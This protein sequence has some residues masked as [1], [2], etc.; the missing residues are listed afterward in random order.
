MTSLYIHYFFLLLVSS[1]FLGCEPVVP[2][3]RYDLSECK[4]ELLEANHFQEEM[5]IDHI[6]VCKKERIMYLY[7]DKE[8]IQEIPISLG[9]NPLGHKI[10]QGDC[11]TPEGEY[12]IRK[13]ICSP[14]Y[15]RSLSISYPRPIDTQK[16]TQRGVKAGGH[17]TIHAQP[18]W[19]ENGNAD[20][21]TLSK[22]W[23]KGCMA[24]SNSIMKELWYAVAEGIPITI[25]E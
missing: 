21:Y 25:K 8:I 2:K 1:L 5:G 13:K 12:T 24:V 11:R 9:K 4:K 16:A 10:K 18:K 15:Y 3:N 23:T 19:N 20:D 6:V 17:I 22:D 14:K 7:K